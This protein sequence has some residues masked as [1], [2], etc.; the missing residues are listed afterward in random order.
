MYI[1]ILY[2]GFCGHSGCLASPQFADSISCVAALTQIRK[3][4]IT[5]QGICV[6][7]KVGS[8]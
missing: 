8:K 5:T 1:L 6:P 3:E 7:Y 4:W 2:V